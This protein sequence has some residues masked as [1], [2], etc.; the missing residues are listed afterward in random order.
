MRTDG[1][2]PGAACPATTVCK[3]VR[4]NPPRRAS[5]RARRP[6]EYLTH[7]EVE[8]LMEAARERGRYG[9]RDVAM[10]LIAYRHG[11]SVAE[12]VGLRWS[13]LDLAQGLLRFD[14]ATAA[15]GRAHPLFGAE[16]LALR[17][18]R[19]ETHPVYVF[20]TERGGPMTQAGFR[21]LLA[22]CGATA[23]I[24][25]PVHPQMLRHACR[26]RLANEGHDARAIRDYLGLKNGRR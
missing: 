23:G 7:A 5:N 26:V 10:I 15:T 18:L 21:K 4:P 20:T 3:V 1:T 16:L 13:Q 24:G 25:F 17:A 11:L 22:R 6:R 2:I 19:H 8:Q 12:L 14:R 9:A